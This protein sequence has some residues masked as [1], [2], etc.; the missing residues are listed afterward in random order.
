M[1]HNTAVVLLHQC[2]AYPLPDW[3]SSPIRFPSASSAET[4]LTAAREVAIIAE[5]FLQDADFL[6]NPQFA[7]CLFVCGRMLLAHSAYYGV[8]LS[9]EFGML[10][11]SLWEVSRRWNGPHASPPVRNAGDNLASK[12]ASRL[13]QARQLGPTTLDIRQAAYSDN[14]VQHDGV[15]TAATASIT[16]YPNIYG[17]SDGTQTFN[18]SRNVQM[19]TDWSESTGMYQMIPADQEASPDSISMAFPPLPMSFRAP[20][21]PATA[22]HSPSHSAM[23]QMPNQTSLQFDCTTGSF[24][25]L[26]S[27]LNYPFLPDQRVSMFSVPMEPL[28][29][30]TIN[31]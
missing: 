15:P 5:K 9:N 22:V 8:D 13:L 7:F 1:T 6:T 28:S 31:Q 30:E 19:N 27:F 12:F 26:R 25:E 18:T 16:T 2:V 20:S 23:G 24:E 29:P 14:Q 11:N 21:A 3:Q 4:C 10:L 17:N